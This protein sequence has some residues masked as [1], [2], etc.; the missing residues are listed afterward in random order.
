MDRRKIV[1]RNT[2][3]STSANVEENENTNTFPIDLIIEILSRLSSKS[4]AICCCV[5]KQWSSL[6][7]RPDFT[8]LY[9][10]SSSSRPRLLFAIEFDSKWHFFSSPQPRNLDEHVSVVATD[11]HM[12]FSGDW[13]KEICLSAN[14]LFYLNDKQI[15]KGKIDRVPVICNPSTGQHLLLPKVRAKNVDLRSF[16]GYDPIEKQFKVLCMTVTIY[17][18]QTSSKEHQVLTLGKGKLSW[19]KIEC[20]IPH[21]PNKQSKGICINGVLYYIARSNMTT[22]IA[23]FDVRSEKFRFIEMDNSCKLRCISSLI[24]Y[25]GKLGVRVYV[26]GSD[27]ELLVLDDSKNDQW[28]KQ[29][30]VL[31]NTTHEVIKSI[32]AT[33]EGEIVWVLS[34][35]TRPFYIFYY[36]VEKKSVRR[37]EV[38][39]IEEKLLI[40]IEDRPEEHFTFIDH[41]ENVMFMAKFAMN[42]QKNDSMD[43][44]KIVRRNTQSS[45]STYVRETL[46]VDLIIEIL[47]RLPAKSIAICRCV[48]KQWDSLLAS[49][50]FVESFLKS[51]LSRPLIWF[52]CRFD[53]KWRYFSSPQPQKFGDNLSVVATKY[54]MGSYENWYMLS[55]QSVHGFTYLSYLSKGMTDRT[56]VICNPCTRQLITLPKL[57]PEHIC[58]QSFLTYDPIEKQFKVLCRTVVYKQKQRPS[59]KNQVLTLG[60]GEL[61]WRNIECP[62]LYHPSPGNN[63]I[64][65]NG[66]LYFKGWINNSMKIVCFDV[67]SE[68]FSFIKIEES[69]IVTLINYK[70]KLGVLVYFNNGS[71]CRA[72]VW[73]LDDT[74]K[75][76]WSKHMFVLP[77]SGLREVKSMWATGTGELVWASRSRTHPV[78]VYYYNLERQ[79]VKRFE[80]KGMESTGVY[81][82]VHGIRRAEVW[83]LDDTKNDNW[84]KHNF[85]LPNSCPGVQSM[86]ATSTG[87]LVWASSRR[88]TH[89]FYVVYYNLERKSFTRVEIKGM[90]NKVSTGKD[91]YEGVFT[92]TNH[93]ENLMVLPFDKKTGLIQDTDANRVIEEISTS[94]GCHFGLKNRLTQTAYASSSNALYHEILQELREKDARIEALEKTSKMILAQNDEIKWQN[95]ENARQNVENMKLIE[96]MRRRLGD[97]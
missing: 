27:D 79:S 46:P 65:I 50:D 71:C 64:C 68:E 20:L 10:T 29:I 92:F 37:V 93:V 73:V 18:R 2:Q 51:S 15:L 55:C 85:V 70:G 82:I 57:G 12:G 26:L 4:I 22:L 49:Q 8:E 95:E 35:W 34:R 47:S 61:L 30:F 21:Y 5:S 97:F 78:Y 77:N 6:L 87:E 41:V 91:R 83:V 38:K 56:R 33:D 45:T 67:S 84:S 48:S 52:T 19:R 9:L 42:R 94:K 54:H 59:N 58:L 53:S 7:R 40:G 74:N 43:R 89:P 86:W 69:H 90:E 3:S 25:K 96:M 24:N 39:G 75:V 14:G 66:V 72:E 80:I 32:W 1:R 60:T 63:E 76:K 31:P 88:W 36:N 16:F 17:R 28:S 23:C 44:R 62:F 11:Y 81:L 13:Y